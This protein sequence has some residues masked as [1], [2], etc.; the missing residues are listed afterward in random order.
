MIAIDT[1]VLIRFLLDDDPAQGARVDRLIEDAV[2]RDEKLF[3]GH[4]VLCETVWVLQDLLHVPKPELL[5]LFE[6]VLTTGFFEI[7]AE[8]VVKAALAAYRN[9]KADFADYLIGE[10]GLSEGCSITATFDRG[11]R[12]AAGFSLL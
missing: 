4:I 1:N 10:V 5:T 12:G 9:G 8:Q 7:Q 6:Y 11:L 2:R 3:L